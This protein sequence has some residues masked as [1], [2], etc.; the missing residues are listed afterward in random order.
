MRK[1]LRDALAHKSEPLTRLELWLGVI[2]LYLVVSAFL[3]GRFASHIG[4][5]E[6]APV[7]P[8]SNRA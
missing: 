4:A 2:T 3:L 7:V 8:V 6:T 5:A 1:A